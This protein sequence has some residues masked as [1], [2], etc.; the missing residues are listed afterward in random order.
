MSDKVVV[1]ITQTESEEVVSREYYE[2]YKNDGIVLRRDY[3]EPIVAKKV[4]KAKVKED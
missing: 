1:Y 2:R 4:E 3:K